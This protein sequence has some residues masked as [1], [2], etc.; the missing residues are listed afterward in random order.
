MLVLMTNCLERETSKEE[1]IEI[2]KDLITLAKIFNNAGYSLYLVGGTLRDRYLKRQNY[3]IDV[4]TDAMPEEVVKLFKKTIPTGIKHGTVTI[5]FKHKNIECTT[6]RKE[7]KYSDGRHPDSVEYG[8]SIIEDLKRRD[9]TMNAIAASLPDGII[10]DPTNG[11]SDIKASLIRAVGNAKDR[12]LEDALRPIRAIRFASQLGFSI[13]EKTLSAIPFTLQRMKSVSIE[14]FQE[15]LN[16]MIE[17]RYFERAFVLMKDSG[18]LSVF[19]PE[20]NF[21]SHIE[22]K[23]LL[24]SISLISEKDR[25]S[26]LT[27]LCYWVYK[28]IDDK[29]DKVKVIYFMLKRL[30]YPNKTVEEI[31]HLINYLAFEEKDLIDDYSIRCFLKSVGKDYIERLFL[32]KKNITNS[33]DLSKF[34]ESTYQKITRIIKANDPLSIGELEISGNDLLA[35]GLKGP[36]I[37]HV[38]TQ[39]LD[40]VLKEPAKNNSQE[41]I[42]LAKNML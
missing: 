36:Q 1:K 18:I 38:L 27:L 37:G 4:A 8:S 24:F 33:P 42:R 11:K 40:V 23:K 21:L 31:T 35:L 3:D 28:N 19:L 16:K 20:L 39:L 10:I 2:E 32:L 22:I 41:L 25:I 6:M 17:G 34:L 26:R 30:K 15:E 7:A 13:E 12:F 5:R 14:R 9:F 29:L